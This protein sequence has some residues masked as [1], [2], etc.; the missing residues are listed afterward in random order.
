MFSSFHEWFLSFRRQHYSKALKER[1]E[2]L[3]SGD[4]DGR[5][6]GL[7]RRIHSL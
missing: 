7:F 1:V 4:V 5:F 3:K 6:P 2:C